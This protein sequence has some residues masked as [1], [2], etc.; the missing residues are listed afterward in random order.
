VVNQNLN[1]EMTVP[2]AT[3]VRLVEQEQVIPRSVGRGLLSSKLVEGRSV[4][5][6]F[7]CSG[8][9]RVLFPRTKRDLPAILINTSGGLTS[10]DTFEFEATAQKGSTLTLSTQA[11]ER[12]YRAKTGPAVTQTTLTI[13][14]GARLNWLPQELILFDGCD[15]ERSLTA[16][17]QG[18]ARFLFVEPVVFGRTAMNETVNQGRFLDHVSIYRN[19][20]TL[21]LDRV[22]LEGDLKNTLSNRATAQGSLAMASIIY[23]GPD[24]EAHLGTV[25]SHLPMTGG[26][27][28]IEDDVIIGRVLAPDGF[29]LRRALLPILEILSQN[30]LPKTWRL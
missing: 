29:E 24:A 9:L 12:G 13:E 7:R 25:R 22:R 5:D 23:I 30:T 14:D 4:I 19:E 15:I 16:N 10:G 6:D 2:R 17:L 20:T 28:M 27:S 21:Y 11:A 1:A 18:D 3:D 26:A 8:A